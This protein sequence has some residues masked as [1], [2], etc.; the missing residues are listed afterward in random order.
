MHYANELIV[1]GYLE[2]LIMQCKRRLIEDEVKQ[3]VNNKQISLLYEPTLS[4]EK[5]IAI[6]F[7]EVHV[8]L[9]GKKVLD[10]NKMHIEKGDIVGITGNGSHL[11]T[12]VLFRLLKPSPGVI[13][14][15]NQELSLISQDNLQ[16]LIA[17][18][19]FDM[20]IQDLTIA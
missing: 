11:I 16:S 5:G 20:Q 6:D 9:C 13:F 15:G 4:N 1:E 18:V 10:I 3:I 19:P 14:I 8:K 17:V 12:S 2:L 7:K